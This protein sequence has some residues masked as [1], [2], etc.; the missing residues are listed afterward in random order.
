MNY[1]F[2]LALISIIV[3]SVFFMYND[4]LKEGLVP[5]E[6]IN[7]KKKETNNA[8]RNRIKQMISIKLPN[9]REFF[10]GFRKKSVKEGMI[11]S[12]KKTIEGEVY[13]YKLRDYWIYSS[14][15]SCADLKKLNE[16]GNRVS[17]ESLHNCLFAGVRFIDLEVATSLYTGEPIVCIGAKAKNENDPPPI[18]KNSDNEKPLKEVLE[19]IETHAFNQNTTNSYKYPILI[20]IRTSGN[21]DDI[22][23]KIGNCLDNFSSKIPDPKHSVFSYNEDVKG[24]VLTDDI[25]NGKGKYKNILR[26]TMNKLEGKMIFIYN[27]VK[28]S[29]LCTQQ[30]YKKDPSSKWDGENKN[31]NCSL[32]TSEPNEEI[33]WK[34]IQISDYIDNCQTFFTT[35]VE[36]MNDNPNSEE[37]TILA[38]AKR[39]LTIV[40]PGWETVENTIKWVKATYNYGFQVCCIP[41][42]DLNKR[43][44]HIEFLDYIK[45]FKEHS[46]LM[47]GKIDMAVQSKEPKDYIYRDVKIKDTEEQN[48]CVSY[49]ARQEESSLGQVLK[50]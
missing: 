7:N 23:K 43:S 42:N 6:L 44:S 36:M 39:K 13:E 5:V 11:S 46:F 40:Y 47:K 2:I 41:F 21:G 20:N 24:G 25:K 48:E 18:D 10:G 27:K 26:E 45:T 4:S 31:P 15:H 12:D 49:A 33:F 1:I 34:Y 17:L 8:L 32:L 38:N 28:G 9:I 37:K 30:D 22:I 16:K 19:Y 35:E 29:Q 50:T 14:F 3:I